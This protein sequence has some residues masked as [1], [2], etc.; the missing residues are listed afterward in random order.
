MLPDTLGVIGLGAIGGS[1]AWQAARSGVKRIVGFSPVPREGA[2]AIRVGA[3][4]EIAADANRVVAASDL[5]VIAAPAQATL[6]LLDEL[7][8]ALTSRAG[9]CTD[10]SSVKAPVVA[11]AGEL[12]LA[13]QFAG[14]HPLA[15]THESGFS[16]ATSDLF[17][18]KVIYV[19]PIPGGEVAA[20]EVA[21]FWERV[22]SA[23]VVTVDASDHDAALAWTSHLP[24]VVASALAAALSNKGP[25]GAAIG[26]GARSTTRLAA[27][28][29]EMWTDILLL[30]K[31]NVLDALE[32]MDQEIQELRKAISNDDANTIGSW[33]EAGRKWRAHLDA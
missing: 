14:S 15:G 30:N 25:R 2:S 32:G 21:D 8:S 13:A 23:T 19:T 10:V 33:L 29:V 9:Y 17:R 11:T 1:V 18:G 6:V 24:Q 4:T 27:S 3:V 7:A 28:N 20:R 12:G 26:S 22:M 31:N 16:A 5:T